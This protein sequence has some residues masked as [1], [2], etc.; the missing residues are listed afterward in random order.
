MPAPGAEL[1]IR[2]LLPLS[3]ATREGNAGHDTEGLPHLN[4]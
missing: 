4:S 1:T 2:R 3:N